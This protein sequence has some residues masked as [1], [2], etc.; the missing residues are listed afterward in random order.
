MLYPIQVNATTLPALIFGGALVVVAIVMCVIVWRGRRAIEH[1]VAHDER[2]R[3][4]ANRQFRRRLQVGVMLA[5]IGILIPLGDQMDKLFAQRP[6]WFL[7]WVLVVMV[8]TIWL[9]LMALGDWLSTVSYSAV[10]ASHLRH[11]RT[12]LEEEIRRYHAMQN[13]DTYDYDDGQNQVFPEGS[14]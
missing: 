5:A 8:L 6:L 12:R 2:A 13:G 9:V 11:E 1:L 10:E 3:L 7:A 4:H 14:P